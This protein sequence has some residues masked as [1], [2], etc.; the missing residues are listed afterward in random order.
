MKKNKRSKILISACLLGEKVRYDGAGLTLSHTLLQYWMSDGRLVSICPEVSAGMSIPRVSAEIC[1]GDG[2]DVL[3]GKA[4]VIEENGRD[5]TESF[6]TAAYNTLTLCQEN[7]IK[8][9]VL[10][11][12][13]PSC[14]S[15]TIYNGSF[16][17]A[18]SDGMGVTSALL[19]AHGIKVFDQYQLE[20]VSKYL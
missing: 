1:G 8:V 2:A 9:A 7:D 14:G 17:G 18:R 10:T 13:S 20:E 11:A 15:V 6:L 19:T 5:V 3:S 4:S 16:T 12:L